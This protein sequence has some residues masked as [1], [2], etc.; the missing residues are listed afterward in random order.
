LFPGKRFSARPTTDF[1]KESLFNIISNNFDIGK[2]RVLDLFSGTGSISY[3]C[4]SRACQA[5]DAVENNRHHYAFIKKTAEELDF[6]QMKI[7]YADAFSFIKRCRTTYDL[8]FADPPYDL[9]GIIS[10]PGLV[11]EH[12]L[13]HP[14]GWLILEHSS[15]YRFENTP[16]FLESRK[17]GS[18]H[19]S[20]FEQV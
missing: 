10:I 6:Q 11:F 16:F 19:F 3:E 5:I 4:A 13:L 2:I 17:Y 9:P 12:N 18:V 7:H 20:I 15:A 8:I 14:G 1:A